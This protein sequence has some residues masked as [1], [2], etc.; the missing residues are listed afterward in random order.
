MPRENSHSL[1]KP[2]SVLLKTRMS[3][4]R[5]GANTQSLIKTQTFLV[6]REKKSLNYHL[7]TSWHKGAIHTIEAAFSCYSKQF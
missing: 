3:S 7:K 2:G 1:S 6:R 4:Y 5:K